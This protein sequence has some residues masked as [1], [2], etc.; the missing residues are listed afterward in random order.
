VIVC[1]DRTARFLNWR[2]FEKP[3][4]EYSVW[5]LRRAGELRAYVVTRPGDLYGNASLIVMDLGCRRGDEEALL[6]LLAARLAAERLAGAAAAVVMGLHPFFAN[7]R[8]LG[9]WHVPDR[10]NPRPI[11]FVAKI[12]R[13]GFDPAVLEASSWFVMLADWDVL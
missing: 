11:R 4:H 8:R 12:L 13:E 5:A 9:F 7:L 6:R 2:F 3:T 1:I 10:W